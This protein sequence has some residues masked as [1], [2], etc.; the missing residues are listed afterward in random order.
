MKIKRYF[1]ADMRQAIR[2]VRD[3]QG[4]D[5]VI[6]SN[7]KV[8]GGVEIIAAV[9]YDE[10]LVDQVPESLADAAPELQ[11]LLG[12][13]GGAPAAA[14]V[15]GAPVLDH[16]GPPIGRGVVPAL[17]P[18]PLI[19][20]P[21]SAGCALFSH[22]LFFFRHAVDCFFTKINDATRTTG[23]D[24][25]SWTR[26]RPRSDYRFRNVFYDI[27]NAACSGRGHPA[28]FRAK[29]GVH[30]ES[31]SQIFWCRWRCWSRSADNCFFGLR[32]RLDYRSFCTL[33]DS[34]FFSFSNRLR[35]WLTRTCGL[36]R[37]QCNSCVVSAAFCTTS[38]YSWACFF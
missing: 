12:W 18:L 14:L 36:R 31:T 9:D 24:R 16:V 35:F 7:R 15:P 10:A 13:D 34:C 25:S 38:N 19:A 2:K 27:Q 11:A 33:N 26:R 28:G 8:E 32:L 20:I 23:R 5:A 22:R 3:E 17:A 6:L 4:P 29:K 30:F 37:R 21:T 1:A